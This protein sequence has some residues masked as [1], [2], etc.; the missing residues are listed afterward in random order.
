[1][2]SERAGGGPGFLAVDLGGTRL[3]VAA[4]SPDGAIVHKLVLSTPRQDPGA[5]ARA[6][7]QAQAE[8]GIEIAGAVVGVPGIVNYAR[9]IV[10]RLP[11]LPGWEPQMTTELLSR[12]LTLP[13][14]LANDADLAALGEYHFGAGQ[15]ASDMVYATSSTGV[16]AGVIIGG[17]L[18]H[19]ALSLAEVGHTII[20]RSR[21]AT[22]EDLGSGTALQRAAG[23]DAVLVEERA[24]A[25][26][27]EAQRLFHDVADAF[28]TGIFNLA[29]LFMPARIVIGGGMSRSGELLLAPVRER[30]ASCDP[31]CPI[32][33]CEVA[34][35]A[36]GDDAGLLGAYSYAQER[37]RPAAEDS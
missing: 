28:A 18:L 12:E 15:G 10:L 32:A 24:R 14:L 36:G 30:L 25:G 9:G 33:N 22:V 31:L 5:L 8:C 34:L 6:M 7:R 35:A 37:F 19:G 17:R 11:N 23:A 1:M 27:E 2:T 3:R 26:D 29:H 13:V 21:W 16:G 20:E 4:F